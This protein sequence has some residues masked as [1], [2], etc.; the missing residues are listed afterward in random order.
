MIQEKVNMNEVK[1]YTYPSRQTLIAGIA[2]MAIVGVQKEDTAI[3]RSHAHYNNVKNADPT[4]TPIYIECQRLKE[5][6]QRGEPIQTDFET[7]LDAL[8]YAC[9][10]VRIRKE[11]WDSILKITYKE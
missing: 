11:E 7:I 2:I 10:S 3:F 8:A 1:E 4:R 9:Q 5:T 6:L